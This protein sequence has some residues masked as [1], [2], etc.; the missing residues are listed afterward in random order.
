MIPED[1]LRRMTITHRYRERWW[2]IP[3]CIV[4]RK[5]WRKVQVY[6]GCEITSMRVIRDGD[7]V[8]LEGELNIP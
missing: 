7:T 4:R 5:Q 3:W 6:E 2:K 1:K 8:R